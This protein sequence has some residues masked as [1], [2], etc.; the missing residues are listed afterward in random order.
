LFS[1]ATA[2]VFVV[3]GG[4]WSEAAPGFLAGNLAWLPVLILV[5][6]LTDGLGEELGWRGFALPR[7][8]SRWPPLTASLLLGLVWATWHLPLLWTEG[9]TLDGHP[10]WLL[11]LDLGAKSIIFTW[12]FLRT[13]GSVLIAVLLHAA[14]NVFVVSPTAS[15]TGSLALPV[16]AVGLEWVLAA[17]LLIA[18]R[19]HPT[20]RIEDLEVLDPGR[21][22][23][24]N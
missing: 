20:R 18:A 3:L 6:A 5:S 9:R 21:R 8:L 14:N 7:L 12:V 16:T 1:L 17:L 15:P 22:S 2:G 19:P 11:F 24:S 23:G 13:R 10:A 4:S